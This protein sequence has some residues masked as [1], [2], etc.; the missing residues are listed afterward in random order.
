[1]LLA[2]LFLSAKVAKALGVF[3][4]VLPIKF[5]RLRLPGHERRRSVEQHSVLQQGAV[6]DGRQHRV[7][8]AELLHDRDELWRLL[9]RV[10]QPIGHGG[11]LNVL[12]S[13]P[14]FGHATD[15]KRLDV[16]D[17]S[18]AVVRENAEPGRHKFPVLLSST[19]DVRVRIDHFAIG[20]QA[21]IQY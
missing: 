7:F 8:A 21:V 20:F 16:A 12:L 19:K 3:R 5:D 2:F 4:R 14:G 11:R 15:V 1:M 13:H 17:N 18:C 6:H 9:D 10:F